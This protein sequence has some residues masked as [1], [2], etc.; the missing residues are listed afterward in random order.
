[1]VDLTM[2]LSTHNPFTGTWRIVWMSEWDQDFVDMEVPG[3]FT[4]DADR[5]GHFQFC[6]V[7]GSMCCKANPQNDQRIDFTWEGSDEADAVSGRGHAEIVAGELQGHI[8]FHQ[9]D[10]SAFRAVKQAQHQDS[11]PL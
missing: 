1:L 11:I 9:G 10:D 4:F 2:Q 5:M 6:L 3:Y 7:Q 8:E